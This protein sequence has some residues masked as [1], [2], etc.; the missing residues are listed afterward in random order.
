MIDRLSA[1]TVRH[2]H[3]VLALGLL[4][5]GVNAATRGSTYLVGQRLLILISLAALVLGVVVM[6]VRAAYFVVQPQIPAF[7]TPGPAWTVF[8]ALGYL[9]PASTHVGALVRSTR[10]GTLST[11]DVVFDVLWVVLAA[12]LVTWAWRGQGIR[13]HPSGV[14]QTWALGSR[15][16]PW[17]ALQVPQIPSAADPRLWLGMRITQP[18][19]VRRRGI[20]QSRGATRRD[21]VDAGFLAAVI[22]HYIAHP[23]HRA[24]IGGQAEYER[25]LA[26]LPGRG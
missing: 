25:L 17:E 6:G 5:V 23:E 7:A 1:A 4:L 20:P 14:R 8:F 2:R 3:V 10:Q 9:G 24:A 19:L 26:A 12:L 21:T 15:T 13:L 22:G 11:F 16:V 18:Q